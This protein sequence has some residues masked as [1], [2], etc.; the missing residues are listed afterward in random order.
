MTDTMTVAMT[1][2]VTAPLT[3]TVVAQAAYDF[4]WAWRRVGI[5]RDRMRFHEWLAGNE[6]DPIGL[7][8]EAAWFTLYDRFVQ[9][10]DARDLANTQAC[11]LM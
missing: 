3:V 8:T 6:V 2:T 5:Y 1:D 4:N 9:W 7:Y 10:E 11:A